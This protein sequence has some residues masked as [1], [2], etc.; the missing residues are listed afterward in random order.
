MAKTEIV[1]FSDNLFKEFNK[2]F[3]INKR[4]ILWNI[5]LNKMCIRD[6]DKKGQGHMNMIKNKTTKTIAIAMAVLLLLMSLA[7]C[8]KKSLGP[9]CM[10]VSYTH[11]DRRQHQGMRRDRDRE[12][13]CFSEP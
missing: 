3:I 11:L 10:T 8:S 6:R 2:K 4:E 5:V 1:K 9:P 13:L 7:G 12:A